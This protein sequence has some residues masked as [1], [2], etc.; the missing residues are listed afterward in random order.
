MDYTHFS[1]ISVKSISL[2]S[3]SVPLDPFA[4]ASGILMECSIEYYGAKKRKSQRTQQRQRKTMVTREREQFADVI[5]FLVPSNL[6]LLFAFC[7]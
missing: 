3:I 2:S 6:A 1:S 4:I 7:L 5:H